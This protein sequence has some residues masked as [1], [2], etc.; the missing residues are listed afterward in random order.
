ME[1]LLEEKPVL[2]QTS[3]L[4]K[5]GLKVNDFGKYVNVGQRKQVTES[6]EKQSLKQ[7]AE[8]VL[9]Q[10]LQ[11]DVIEHVPSIYFTKDSDADE[12]F[13]LLKYGLDNNRKIV[14]SFEGMPANQH[15]YLATIGKLY[16][17]FPVETVN[18]NITIT[19]LSIGGEYLMERAK[20]G[21]ILAIYDKPRLKRLA[22]IYHELLEDVEDYRNCTSYD[23][24]EDPFL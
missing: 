10:P 3:T 12:V 7:V 24:N 14:I 19:G 11:I 22:R 6:G 13:T 1:L 9:K 21:A 5:T 18:D 17:H 20:K 4:T 8:N 15:F 16:Q 2:E 23:P